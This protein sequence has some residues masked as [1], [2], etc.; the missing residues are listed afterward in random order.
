MQSLHRRNVLPTQDFVGWKAGKAYFMKLLCALVHVTHHCR[1]DTVVDFV[2][3]L[4]VLEHFRSDSSFMKG[5][6]QAVGICT[7]CLHHVLTFAVSFYDLK[8]MSIAS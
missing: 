8:Q 5:R 6:Q 3:S 2:Y 7:G 1:S 4:Q